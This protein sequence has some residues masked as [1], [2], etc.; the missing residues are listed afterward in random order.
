LSESSIK[1]FLKDFYEYDAKN[2]DNRNFIKY[3]SNFEDIYENLSIF[4]KYYVKER[5]KEIINT[6]RKNMIVGKTILDCGCGEGFVSLKLASLG[7]TV[8]GVDLSL[9]KIRMAKKLEKCTNAQ[10]A[11]FIVADAENLPFKEHAFNIVVLSEV[12]EHLPKPKLC[13][14]ELNLI[15][16]ENGETYITVPRNTEIGMSW[17]KKKRQK[18]ILII[19]DP[20]HFDSHIQTFSRREF[21]ELLKKCGFVIDNAKGIIFPIP[22]QL[23]FILKFSAIIKLTKGVLTPF[24]H[25]SILFSCHKSKNQSKKEKPE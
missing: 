11:E 24:C 3:S 1:P 6:I 25:I 9:N 8:L 13:L 12:I 21:G 10:N 16:A 14:N 2:Q 18:K 22:S 19:C 20:L 5:Q 7:A 17:L 15:L 4:E 23:T